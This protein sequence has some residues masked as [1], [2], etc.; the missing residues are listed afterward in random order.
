MSLVMAISPSYMSVAALQ[1]NLHVHL[2]VL[3]YGVPKG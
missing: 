1:F 3:G 2:S